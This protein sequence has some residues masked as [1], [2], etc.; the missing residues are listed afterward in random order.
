MFSVEAADRCPPARGLTPSFPADPGG[1]CVA[2]IACL[3]LVGCT[4]FRSA[5]PIPAERAQSLPTEIVAAGVLVE[6]P[7]PGAGDSVSTEESAALAQALGASAIGEAPDAETLALLLLPPDAL[8]VQSTSLG[9][10][11][12]RWGSRY[13]AV[14]W[15]RTIPLAHSSSWNVIIVIPIPYIWFWFN[16]PIPLSGESGVPHDARIVR[17]VDLEQ[18]EIVSEAYR[19][20]RGRAKRKPFSQR[21]LADA[22]S[23]Q[24]WGRP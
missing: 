6:S 19:I 14:G 16:W 11:A 20:E 21:Q 9:E 10:L 7:D 4:G 13:A 5:T 24:G 15:R 23:R 1:L 18:A 17:I 8:A 12:N 3:W 2:V 22:L